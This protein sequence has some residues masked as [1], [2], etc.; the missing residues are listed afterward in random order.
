M[1]GR[2]IRWR[3]SL[4]VVGSI[5]AVAWWMIAGGN[6]SIVMI[7]FGM[8]PELFQGAEVVIDGEVAGRLTPL[9]AAT[10]TG[11]KV[12]EGDHEVSLRH[13]KYPSAPTTVTSGFGGR[14]V[15]LI[16]DVHTRIAEGTRDTEPVLV[17]T[18]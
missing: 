5:L 16:A 13:P 9:G 3:A 15:M 18:H 7:E 12:D 10:R 6:Q 2:L 17:L 14:H 4:L 1:L 8:Y 11:F